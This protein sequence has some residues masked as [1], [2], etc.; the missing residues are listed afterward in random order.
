MVACALLLAEGDV[1]AQQPLPDQQ[2]FL[3]EVRDNLLS[4]QRRQFAYAYKERRTDFHMNPF[5]RI[6]TDGSRLVDVVPSA[7]GRFLTR[8]LIERDGQPVKDPEVRRR[9]IEPRDRPRSRGRS[10]YADVVEALQFELTGREVVDGRPMITIAFT[11]RPDAR[12]ESREGKMARAFS[13]TIWIDE[14]AR[15]VARVEALAGDSLSVGFGLVARLSK[16]TTAS[17]VREPVADGIWL[18]T[19]LRLK[20]EG[21]AMLFIRKVEVDFAID[22]YDYRLV[23]G[24]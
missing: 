12:P 22:W 18:P 14:A 3:A 13:G 21:R 19:S 2:E 8:R 7:D 24:G 10:G 16:G 4:A 20:G 5:G 15:E 9:E 17:L 23:G 11:P 1:P 6:G